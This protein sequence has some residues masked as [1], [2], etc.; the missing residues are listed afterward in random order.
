MSA[1]ILKVLASTQTQN[2]EWSP[3]IEVIAAN[4]HQEAA[5]RSQN[6]HLGW[7][8]HSPSKSSHQTTKLCTVWPLPPSPA[9]PQLL[10]SLSPGLLIPG[11]PSTCC[12]ASASGHSMLPLP[13]LLCQDRG[14]ALTRNTMIST[15]ATPP[16]VVQQEQFFPPCLLP[17]NVYSPFRTQLNVNSPGKSPCSDQASCLP[18]AFVVADSIDTTVLNTLLTV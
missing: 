12:P 7:S 2:S 13:Q 6:G 10:L 14:I 9:L 5:N 11:P 1:S 15:V 17:V 16:R 18:C 8:S 4:N 3:W